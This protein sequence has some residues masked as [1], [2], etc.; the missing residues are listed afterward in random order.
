MLLAVKNRENR[1]KLILYSAIALMVGVASIVPLVFLMSAKA[2]VSPD[3]QP[4]FNL[5]IPYAYIGNYLDNSSETN[6]TTILHARDANSNWVPIVFQIAFKATPNFDPK[7]VASDAIFEYYL[8]EIF[9]EKGFIENVPYAAYASCN[10]SKPWGV[11]LF[12]RYN[13]FDSNSSDP[14]LDAW[15]VSGSANG[16]SL[17]LKAG[18]GLDWNRSLGQPESMFLT[19]RRQGWVILNSNSTTARLADPEVILQIQLEKFGDGFLHNEVIPEDEMAQTDPLYPGI[20]L[21][22]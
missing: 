12:S 22:R 15:G 5:T 7:A 6:R 4:Q 14:P 11:F 19:V 9:S 18:P 20:K 10:T 3:E 1:K 2:E 8:I 17:G 16:T 13:W 21:Y